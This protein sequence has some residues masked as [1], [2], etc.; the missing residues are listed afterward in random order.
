M[1]TLNTGLK[2][3]INIHESSDNDE[4]TAFINPA[5]MTKQ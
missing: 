5:V 3:T 2:N 4:T 1:E